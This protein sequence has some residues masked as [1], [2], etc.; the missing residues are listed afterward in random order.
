MRKILALFLWASPFLLSAQIRDSFSDGNFT[1]DPLWQGDTAFFMVNSA[2]ELQSKTIG[3]A[4]VQHLSTPSSFAR[5]RQWEFTFR[6]LVNPSDNNQCRFY[7]LASDTSLEGNVQGYYIKVGENGNL[8]SYD[9]YRQDGSTSQKIIDGKAGR[10]SMNSIQARVRLVR[11]MENNWTLWSDST[12]TGLHWVEEGSTF[13]ATYHK[14]VCLGWW[15]KY[16]SINSGKFFLDDVSVQ[17]AEKDSI[18]PYIAGVDVLGPK[19]LQLQFSEVMDTSLLS[20][21]AQYQLSKG[22]RLDSCKTIDEQTL[23]LYLADS[24]RNGQYKLCSFGLLDENGNKI[25]TDTAVF[26]TYKKPY[27]AHWKDIVFTEIFPDPSPPQN[28]PI[29]EFIEIYNRYSEPIVLKDWKLTDGTSL[30]KFDADTLFPSEYLILCAKTDTEAFLGYGRVLGLTN[31]PSLNNSGDHMRLLSNDDILVDSL[32]YRD[33]WYRDADKKAGGYTLEIIDLNNPYMLACNWQGA[34]AIHGGTPGTRNSSERSSLA[35]EANCSLISS[36]QL[37]ITF[38]PA[39]DSLS[40]ADPKQYHLSSSNTVLELH[41]ELLP[42]SQQVQLKW[43]KALAKGQMHVLNIEALKACNQQKLP[44]FSFNLDLPA[45]PQK[46]ALLINEVLFYPKAGQADF[47]EIYH[48]GKEAIDL[49]TVFMA[50]R[51]PSGKAATFHPLSKTPRWIQPGEYLVFTEQQDSLLRAYLDLPA[52]QCLKMDLP[53]FNADADA[54]ILLAEDSTVI[55]RFDYSEKMHFALLEDKQGVSLERIAFD[56]P[57]DDPTNWHSASAAAGYATP[58]KPNS[59]ALNELHRQEKVSLNVPVFSPDNDGKDDVLSLSCFIDTPGE[60]LNL[61]IYS[62]Q[63][64][65]VK[66]LAKEELLGTSNTFIW[67]GLDQEQQNLPVGIYIIYAEFFTAD[68]WLKRIRKSC[69]LARKED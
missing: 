55:D 45:L 3:K 21:P 36:D 44:S 20:S 8:D 9:L 7:V 67:D 31:F 18:S 48:P 30:A 61:R 14:S 57:T 6:M 29:A 19:Q 25:R 35:V 40:A 38:Y 16:S 66:E 28:L 59:Q 34:I 22:L 52:D 5:N 43:Q 54:V 13:D 41:S 10:A 58:G 50:D 37:N 23:R 60:F 1:K 63:G 33:T 4:A 2:K 11:D 17:Q 26:F 56:L 69:I 42:D 51:A 64:L 12:G 46:N 65:F 62:E 15:I 32:F 39:V 47:V 24:L 68:G 27:Q 49:R 53:S